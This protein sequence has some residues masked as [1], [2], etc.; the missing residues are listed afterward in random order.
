MFL[1][2]G[3]LGSAEYSHAECIYFGQ[4]ENVKDTVIYEARTTEELS[5]SFEKAVDDYIELCEKN[6]KE[7]IYI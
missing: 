2:K 3:F 4:I 7:I 6:S 1:Y 5:K